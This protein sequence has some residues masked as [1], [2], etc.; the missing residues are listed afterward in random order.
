MG[1]YEMGNWEKR[2]PTKSVIPQPTHRQAQEPRGECRESVLR[3]W[4]LLVCDY[5]RRR[6]S[7]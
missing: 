3:Y 7:D 1:N 5:T 4:F 6:L 2:K